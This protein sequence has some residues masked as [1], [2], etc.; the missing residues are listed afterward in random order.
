MLLPVASNVAAGDGDGDVGQTVPLDIQSVLNDT[1][2][3]ES[4]SIT[5][6]GF[7]EGASLN[8]GVDNQDGSYT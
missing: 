1:D 8:A 5:I 2:G 7:P 3:S 4:L 6:S